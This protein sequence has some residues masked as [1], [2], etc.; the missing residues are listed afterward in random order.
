[1]LDEAYSSM[2]R[3]PGG[4]RLCAEVTLM[5]MCDPKLSGSNEAILSRLSTLED[6]L[7]LL[8]KG[9]TP[10]INSEP[11]PQKQTPVEKEA[12]PDKETVVITP[13]ASDS[14]SF[15]DNWDEIVSKV[16]QLNVSIGSFLKN[17]IPSYSKQNN[18][19]YISSTAQITVTM[20]STEKNK[21]IIFDA[22]VCCDIDIDS[23]SQIEF[24]YKNARSQKNDLD[25]F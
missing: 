21:K 9:V 22:M 15:V 2:M 25:E 13:S 3:N 17:C 7:V 24:V 4:K 8:S 20:L 11:E 5:K 23:M 18:K 19:Y 10:V 12:K 16:S 14:S 1:M 6:K